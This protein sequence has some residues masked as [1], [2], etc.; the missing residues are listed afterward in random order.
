M[1]E[2][3][4]GPLLDAA[5]DLQNRLD[6]I[7]DPD[8]DF[9]ACTGEEKAPAPRGRRC[10]STLYRVGQ[11][12]C[13]VEIIRRDR[14]FL[15][16]REPEATR[17]VS[18]LVVAVSDTFGDD[19]YGREFMLWREEQRAIG[20]RMIEREGETA[21]CVGYATFVERYARDY[22][23]WFRR[24]EGKLDRQTATS[25]ARL[26][27]LGE[28]LA[29]SSR[30]S[31]P[32]ELRYQALGVGRAATRGRTAESDA[33][34]QRFDHLRDAL[35]GGRRADPVGDR[36]H[37]RV[38]VRDG[39]A[40]AGP[41]EQLDVVLAV[42]ERDGPLAREAEVLGQEPEPGALR[43]VAGSRTRGRTAATSRCRGGRRSA[44]SCAP[45]GRRGRPGR[46]WRRASSAAPRARRRGRRPRAAGGSGSRHSA[47]PPASPRRRR[48]RRPRSS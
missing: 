15:K 39:D 38:R 27:E 46:R 7:L 8:R 30:R 5:F 25:S 33:R 1:L 35:L 13:W 24:F 10:T 47:R 21:S 4:R 31:I 17:A 36:Q 28:I 3:Y 34:R 11:Y 45:R 29:R 12:L 19:R 16:L 9:L 26:L 44:P 23:R 37:A 14:L 48:A 43:H 6:N 32:S 40:E 22:A 18:E 2:R 20:E 42:A 41:L